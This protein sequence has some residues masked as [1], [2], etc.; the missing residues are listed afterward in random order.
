MWILV[1]LACL[2]K[3]ILADVLP[4]TPPPNAPNTVTLERILLPEGAN[5]TI[6]V[7]GLRRAALAN[8]KVARA[9]AVPPHSLLLTAQSKGNTFVHTW[10][11]DGTE[12]AFAVEV[13]APHRMKEA[14]GNVVHV[15]MQFL[16]IDQSV[17]ENAGVHWPDQVSLA[18]SGLVH[19]AGLAS[20]LSYTVGLGSTRGWLQ[21]LVEEGRAKLLASPDLYVRLGEEAQFSSGGEIPIPTTMENFGRVQK[22]VEWKSFGTSVKVKP[23]SLDAYHLQSDVSVEMSDL[24]Q[25]QAIGGIP[26]LNRR[27]LATKI[28]SVDGETIL[29]S[30]LVRQLHSTQDEGLPVLK[31]IPILGGLFGTRSSNSESHEVLMA[32]TLSMA[33]PMETRI[34]WEAFEEKFHRAVP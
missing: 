18:P 28:N 21:Q 9:R 11:A 33:T 1:L 27:R 22:H 23:E 30:G 20:V 3:T 32:M 29:L 15:A 26:A 19:G 10:A 31:D 6:Q 5:Q 17:K 2:A 13:V 34:R 7:T 14:Q 12:R 24:N 8:P 25:G 16:E 4:R